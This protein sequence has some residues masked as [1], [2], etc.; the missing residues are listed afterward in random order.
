MVNHRHVQTT[1]QK[2]RMMR[3]LANGE[4]YTCADNQSETLYDEGAG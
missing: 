3:A 2:Y 4:P 1:N